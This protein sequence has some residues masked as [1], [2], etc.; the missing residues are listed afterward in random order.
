MTARATGEIW[1]S[2]ALAYLRKA[3]LVPVARNFHCRHGEIDLILRD[4]D[5]FVFAEVRYRHGSAHGDGTVSVGAAKRRR[6]VQAA[7]IFLQTHPQYASLPCRFDVIGC[8]GTP[9]HPSF[10]WTRNAFDA[11]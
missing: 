6:L 5:V 10:E 11:W 9:Q 8:A 2:A 7:Q 4:G 3:G 1:E